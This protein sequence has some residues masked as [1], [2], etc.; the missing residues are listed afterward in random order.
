MA[1]PMGIPIACQPIRIAFIQLGG[2][3]GPV[4]TRWKYG[5]ATQRIIT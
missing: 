1:R 4:G 3:D 2:D 5:P